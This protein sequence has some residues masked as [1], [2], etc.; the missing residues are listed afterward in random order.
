MPIRLFR[1]SILSLLLAGL[2]A[3]PAS[4]Q[5]PTIDY[6]RG[7]SHLPNPFAPYTSRSVPQPDLSNSARLN[8][9]IVDGRLVLSLQ[10]A[11]YLA[12][13][14]NLDIAVQRYI[15]AL[16]D[17]D[18]LR[19]KGGGITRGTGGV[20]TASA[21]GVSSLAALDPVLNANFQWQ[22]SEF[23]V[24]NPVA[25][26]IG[27][28]LAEIGR[29]T[30][31][32]STYNFAYTQGFV[33][34]TSYTVQW[35]NSRTSSSSLFD[36]FNPALRSQFA[37]SVSQPLLNGFG[38]A[39]NKRFIRVA[40]NNKTISDQFFSQQV[41]DIVSGV[42][43]SYW[44][45]IFALED[46]KVKEQSLALAE[47]LYNDNKR[48]VEIGT[49]APIEVVRAEA[50]VARTRQDLIVSRTNLLQQQTRLKDLIA[51]NPN[52]PLVALVEIEPVDHPQVPDVPEALPVQDAIQVAMQKRPELI[53]AQLD[54]TNRHLTVRG[55]RNAMLPRVDAFGFYAGRGLSGEGE[56][57]GTP[58]VT[59]GTPVILADGT[60]AQISGQN[61]FTQST[62]LQQT[63]L[64]NRGIGT[65]ATAAIQ[66][67][68]PDYGVGFSIQLPIRN[69]V[70]QSEMDRALVEQRQAQTRYQ[71]TVNTIIVEV[72]NTQIA[73]EQS[74][75]RIDAAVQGRRLAQET[76]DAEQK[77][78]QLGASTI[79]LVIQAQ[80]DLSAARSA[81]VRALVDFERAR[82]DFDRA[83]GRTLERSQI[84]FE[85]AKSGIV[86]AR[87]PGA[88]P[89]TN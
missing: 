51:K 3:V 29:F 89:N 11:I 64:I 6:T 35:N 67:D 4:A 25:S 58:V 81:E 74:R 82:V 75:A 46:V 86:T 76:L 42:K 68:F 16:A 73:L 87:A 71:R 41:M 52:D 85:D 19:S 59:T 72:R 62:Q 65:A 78:F 27:L 44:E 79:F 50:E 36:F 38:F 60:P 88:P 63:G 84:S 26:A 31:H 7:K 24:N 12:L 21:V 56:T 57:L 18:I 2:L 49:L 30:Q 33:T 61:L 14:N 32:V 45:L 10:D 9:L 22:R 5:S 23:P 55:A 70:A 66:G 8:D 39:Q 69:R 77:K 37:I 53:Q 13:E 1:R 34:G 47:K 54:L 28:D 80:R 43:Q 20:G 15:P 48:Q 17:T 40:K 83:L